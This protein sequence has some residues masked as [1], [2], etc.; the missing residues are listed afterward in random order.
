MMAMWTPATWAAEVT[1]KSLLDTSNWFYE[2]MN[3]CVIDDTKINIMGAIGDQ[4]QMWFSVCMIRWMI[5]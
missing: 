1:C 2:F 5:D 4:I 3:S